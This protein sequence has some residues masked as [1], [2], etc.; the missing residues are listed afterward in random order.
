ML[1][2]LREHAAYP[3]QPVV[4]IGHSKDFV[5]EH[6]FDR[7][8]AGLARDDSIHCWNMSDYVREALRRVAAAKVA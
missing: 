2:R 3:Q 1:K 5:N 4:V 8:L 7:F 6:E